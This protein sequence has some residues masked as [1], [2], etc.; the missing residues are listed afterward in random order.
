MNC[1][2]CNADVAQDRY[3]AGYPYCMDK[4]CVLKALQSRQANLRLIN[5]PKQGYAYVFVD[6]PDLK[7]GKSSGRQ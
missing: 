7:Y 5:M 2:Y 4:S 1:I 6:S 3:D